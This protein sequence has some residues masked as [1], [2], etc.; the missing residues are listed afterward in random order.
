[1]QY[2]GR[3]IATA[4]NCNA[5]KEDEKIIE[6]YS[7]NRERRRKVGCFIADV[8]VGGSM[9]NVGRGQNAAKVSRFIVQEYRLC[10]IKCLNALFQ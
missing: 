8:C 1:M 7:G 3:R 10:K 9:Q 5:Q 2:S 6:R 4:E